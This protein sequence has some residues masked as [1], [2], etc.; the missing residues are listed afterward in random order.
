MV[1]GN[2]QVMITKKRVIFSCII[3]CE[4]P[5]VQNVIILML[6]LISYQQITLSSYCDTY[7]RVRII[8]LWVSIPGE[9]EA[10]QMAVILE[11]LAAPRL[12]TLLFKR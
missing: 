10:A 8:L 6:F 11:Q 3:A 7:I 9:N 2:G 4:T 12:Q 5:E 1:V